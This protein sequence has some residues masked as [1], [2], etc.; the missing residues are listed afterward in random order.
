VVWTLVA[1]VLVAWLTRKGITTYFFAEAFVYLG[2]YREAGN[3][4]LGT[5]LRPHTEIFYRPSLWAVNLAWNLY[6]PPD[7]L[8]YHLRNVA[9]IV[10]NA[11]L[12]HRLL[13]RLVPD[14]FGRGV[15]MTFY[16]ISKV[17]LTTIGYV[18]TFSTILLLFATL[19]MFVAFCR[20][21]EGRRRL[22]FAVTLFFAAFLVFSKDYGAV[23]VLLLP[24]L[25]WARGAEVGR[26][27]RP[28]AVPLVALIVAYG[29]LRVWVAPA[30][31]RGTYEPRVHAWVFAKKS[32]QAATTLANLSLFE[33]GGTMGARGVTRLVWADDSRAGRVA[34]GVLLIAFGAVFVALVWRAKPP[35][36][37]VVFCVGWGA[38]LFAP[39][40]L[41]RNEQMYYHNDLVAAA[42]VLL[43]ASAVWRRVVVGVLLV[44]ALNAEVSQRSMRYVWYV[45]SE[46][47]RPV[48]TLA[49]PGEKVVFVTSDRARWDFTL[50]AGGHAPFVQAVLERPELEVRVV[51]RR[52]FQ[53][54]P[55][56]TIVDVDLWSA[57][58]VASAFVFAPHAHEA[59]EYESG[60]DCL[61]TPNQNDA[62]S[63][64]AAAWARSC[65]SR[66][67]RVRSSAISC[68]IFAS[69]SFTPSRAMSWMRAVSLPS[70]SD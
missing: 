17:H 33:K 64:S 48:A 42:G 37:L 7:A 29:G 4:F 15:A 44:L 54:E 25:A 20:W 45:L 52:T 59:P 38:L 67:R 58:A 47:A 36:A 35:R 69:S 32:V 55:G 31:A 61:R 12:L 46:E 43:G 49:I 14:R 27:M 70:W 63:E 68:C 56:A 24:L 26:V 39:T 8:L 21:L 28:F 10:L 22:D 11:L 53:G 16:A 65:S 3:S 57:E 13:L 1:A 62:S 41:G 30:P 34:E 19:A 23:A 66:A 2:S 5:L 9:F 40:L 51:D 6:A 60:G 50:T 18:A